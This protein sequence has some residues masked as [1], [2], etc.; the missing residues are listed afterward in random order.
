MGV[1]PLAAGSL[2]GAMQPIA[3][4]TFSL[5]FDHGGI[6]QVAVKWHSAGLPYCSGRALVTTC[7]SV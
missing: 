7:E 1:N 3:P 2:Q 4:R 6:V 5:I